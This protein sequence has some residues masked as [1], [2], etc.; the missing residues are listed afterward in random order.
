MLSCG[1]MVSMLS[2]RVMVSCRAKVSTWYVR[3]ISSSKS[4]VFV[5]SCRVLSCRV[6]VLSCGVMLSC[7]VMVLV[8]SCRTIVL[9]YRN[10]EFFWGLFFQYIYK[11]AVVFP[12]AFFFSAFLFA[13]GPPPFFGSFPFLFLRLSFSF[14]SRRKW[15]LGVTMGMMALRS[16]ANVEKDRIWQ[17]RFICALLSQ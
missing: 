15:F 11:I 13:L 12:A 4:K 5:L 10:R 8:L 6:L 17:G 2:C 16:T 1:V 7:R 14:F 9:R 3:H